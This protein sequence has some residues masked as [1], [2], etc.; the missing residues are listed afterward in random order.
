M[1]EFSDG[2]LLAQLGQTDMRLPIQYALTYPERLPTGLERLDLARIGALHFQEPDH[3]KF[4]ALGLAFEAARL[5]GTMPA[6]L[7]AAD[8]EVVE[9]FLRREI[10]FLSIFK[11]VEKV[12][13]RH[14]IIKNPSL[15]DI[16]QADQWARQ[17]SRN[18]MKGPGCR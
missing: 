11:V 3:K 13:L 7:N 10:G 4:P 18:I 1:V 12:V 15:Q 14:K 6:V 9:S 16:L 2:T 17:E 8:E 5:A